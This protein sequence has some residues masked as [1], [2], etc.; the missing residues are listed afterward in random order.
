[1]LMLSTIALAGRGRQSNATLRAL[2]ERDRLLCAAASHFLPGWSSRAAAHELNVMLSRYQLGAW[3]RERVAE[4]V[5]LRHH[6]RIEAC[7]WQI[8]R[9]HDYVPSPRTIRRVLDAAK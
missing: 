1:M 4:S 5:P 2:A 8:S 3:R 7:C 6:G 9:L